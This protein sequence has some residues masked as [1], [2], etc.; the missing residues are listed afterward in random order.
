[1]PR[2][3][4]FKNVSFLFALTCGTG[5]VFADQKENLK[6]S[7]GNFDSNI[8]LIEES[9]GITKAKVAQNRDGEPTFGGVTGLSDQLT[10]FSIPI[11]NASKFKGLSI[12]QPILNVKAVA[13]QHD[14]CN[15]LQFTITQSNIKILHHNIE[16]TTA[17]RCE[18]SVVN[19]ENTHVANFS[20]LLNH[21]F[22]Y[23]CNQASPKS[24]A[25]KTARNIV[26]TCIIEPT[27]IT[28]FDF[29]KKE[30]RD[31]SPIAGF[32]NLVFLNFSGNKISHL[33]LGIFD[34][35]TELKILF[36]ENNKIQ[37][38]PL[39]SLDKLTKLAWIWI[40]D[41]QISDLPLGVF[42]KLE[43]L[44]WLS[45]SNNKMKN[46]PEGLLAN[47]KNLHSIE[48]SNNQLSVFPADISK[49]D[50]LI[51][52]EIESNEITEI[53]KNAFANFKR[54]TN[55]LTNLSLSGNR[56]KTLPAGLFANLKHL[57]FLKLAN[58][59]ISHLPWGIFDGLSNLNKAEFDLSG[60]P[61]SQVQ[62]ESIK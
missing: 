49:L 43:N 6:I 38:I 52:I 55:R 29:E 18:Y 26:S 13:N 1:M 35:F 19:F 34:K 2:C 5:T 40:M 22:N 46:L 14:A 50:Q 54:E 39:G 28:G 9:P 20:I 48:L 37:T 47:L 17:T 57:Y 12:D 41:N 7:L 51:S 30:I 11:I 31:L 25:Y 23:W 21:T 33:P 4:Y 45:M 8:F 27:S 16:L 44:E 61:I 3:F 58:N 36:L 15:K 24:E 42:D 10:D 53:P 32:R 59:N 60:N 62:W 56:L